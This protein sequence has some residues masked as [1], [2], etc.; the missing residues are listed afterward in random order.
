MLE[1][2]SLYTAYD[3]Y[4][5]AV[6]EGYYDGEWTKVSFS[7]LDLPTC[8]SVAELVVSEVSQNGANVSWAESANNYEIA[9]GESGFVVN[10]IFVHSLAYAFSFT[11]RTYIS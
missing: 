11:A 9:F 7:T 2:L 5:R 4:V 1:K 8:E 3:V 10:S 6:K